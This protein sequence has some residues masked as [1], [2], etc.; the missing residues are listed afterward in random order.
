[1]AIPFK[2]NLRNLRLR[3]VTSLLTAG[4][5]GLVTL[6]FLGMFSMGLGIER[7]LLSSGHPLNLILLRTGAT[8]ESHSIVTK[9]QVDD[10]LSIEGI[11]RDAG[12]RP[13]VS[14]E[15]VTVANLEKAGGNKANAA[16]RGV[17]PMARALRGNIEIVAG[18]WFRPAVGELVVGV[19]AARR[20]KRMGV[21]EAI[22]F[23]GR[24]WRVVGHFSA[25]GQSFESEIWGDVDDLKAQFQLDTSAVLLRCRDE[26]EM[27][28]IANVVRGDKRLSLDAKPHL[29][30]F[31]ENNDAAEML[32]AMGSM[33]G[34]VLAIGAVFGAAN[35]M[36]TAVASRTREVATMQVLGF[37]RLAVG[38]SFVIEAALLG[39]AGG[40][41]GVLVGALLLDGAAAGTVNWNTFS[42]MAFKFRVGPGL[43]AAGV[44]LAVGTSVVGGLLPAWRASR[45]GLARSL[46]GL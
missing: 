3:W 15:L 33:V 16:I 26:A 34:V 43:M 19:G 32:K 10:V 25:E 18:E 7:S 17:G 9:P 13:L 41:A 39:L 8:A 40:L 36:F 27:T 30:Y 28:R 6:I 12:G 38:L 22:F 20:F 5:I 2:Y 4:G 24:E 23:R 35:T 46:R 29:D 1:M 21:G 31:R 44:A 14:P 37:S 11:V 45:T 42:D